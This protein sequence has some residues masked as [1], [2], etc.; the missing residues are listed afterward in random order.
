MRVSKQ[1]QAQLK[2]VKGEQTYD[3]LIEFLIICD[4]IHHEKIE[5]L[6]IEYLSE[7]M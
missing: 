1:T 3:E 7:Y 6:I 4:E 5:K 2:R